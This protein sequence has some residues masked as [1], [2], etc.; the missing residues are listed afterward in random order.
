ML[1]P[2]YAGVIPE[3]LTLNFKDLAFP[4][5]CGGDPFARLISA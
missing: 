2:A 3:N 5:M 1:F 4:R